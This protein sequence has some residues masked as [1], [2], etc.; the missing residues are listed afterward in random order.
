MPRVPKLQGRSVSPS[1]GMG[2]RVPVGSPGSTAFGGSTGAVERGVQSLGQAAMLG[3]EVRRKQEERANNAVSRGLMAQI[4]EFENQFLYDQK[5]GILN[6]RGSNA[7]SAPEE[8]TKQFEKFYNAIDETLVND[9]QRV[10][11]SIMAEKARQGMAKKVSQHVSAQTFEYDKEQTQS[12]IANEK[13]IAINSFND[14]ERVAQSIQTQNALIDQFVADN[15]MSPEYAQ[16]MKNENFSETHIGVVENLITVDGDMARE[17]FEQNKSQIDQSRLNSFDLDRKILSYYKDNARK[18]EDDLIMKEINGELTIDDLNAVSMPIEKGGIGAQRYQLQLKRLENSYNANLAE[19]VE[20][21]ESGDVR[22]TFG[23]DA[24]EFVTLVGKLVD[25]RESKFT[26]AD[27]ILNAYADRKIDS[28]EKKSLTQVLN[29]LRAEEVRQKGF[30]AFSNANPLRWFPMK[31]PEIMKMIDDDNINDEDVRGALKSFIGDVMNERPKTEE[32]VERIKQNSI[33]KVRKQKDP[34]YKDF[35]PGDV[36]II[37]G[38]KYKL[39]LDS[40]GRLI[41]VPVGE[42]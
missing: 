29:V 12:A 5:S 27:S 39:Q 23:F 31:V 35:K 42:E 16:N 17:Y 19:M 36:E 38:K 11:F 8:L 37:N 20:M 14:P 26:I 3:I 34:R 22:G 9:E 21:H 41:P 4:S 30:S 28:E 10:N 15:G 24:K 1:A 25:D 2:A 40:Q 13:Q 32:D 33:N 6:R 18:I 7:F